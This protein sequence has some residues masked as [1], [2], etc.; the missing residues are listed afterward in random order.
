MKTI[1]E[2]KALYGGE[3]LTKEEWEEIDENTNVEE[4]EACGLSG[5]HDGFTFMHTIHFIDGTEMDCYFRMGVS[6]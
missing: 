4:V 3:I 5:I 2:L 6:D 1:E